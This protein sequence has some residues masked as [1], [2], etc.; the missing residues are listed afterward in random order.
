MRFHKREIFDLLKAWI[1]ISIAFGIVL[2]ERSFGI[3]LLKFI[4]I[5]LLTAGIGFIAHELSHRYFARKYKCYAE[6][7]SNDIMLLIAIVL[8]FA[9]F[10]F[11]APGAVWFSG[12]VNKEQRGIISMSGPLAN[13]VVALIF[14]PLIFVIPT[15]ALYGM[16]IN[17]WLAFFNLIPFRGFDGYKVLQW[18]K[19]IYAI[20]IVVS[21]G[22]TVLSFVGN[23]IFL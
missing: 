3:N 8:S 2:S 10:V 19:A 15:F 18:N 17:S 21:L 5:A 16:M 1:A 12:Y 6:F 11:A 23:S 14:L 22:L 4:G 13:I 9:G 20:L 7:R